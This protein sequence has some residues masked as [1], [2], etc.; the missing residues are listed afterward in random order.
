MFTQATT[1]NLS[2]HRTGPQATSCDPLALP[3]LLSLEGMCG[4]VQKTRPPLRFTCICSFR[5]QSHAHSHA[6]CAWR[7]SCHSRLEIENIYHLP[8][9]AHPILLVGG[10]GSPQPCEGTL[11]NSLTKS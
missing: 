3:L 8:S 7:R 1:C 2:T 5:A 4:R 10:M 6:C 11:V 9:T